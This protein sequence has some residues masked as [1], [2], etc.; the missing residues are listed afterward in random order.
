MLFQFLN[1]SSL[2]KKQHRH[3]L[4]MDCVMYYLVGTLHIVQCI[5]GLCFYSPVFRTVH[6]IADELKFK[7]RQH[8]VQMPASGGVS[9][10]VFRASSLLVVYWHSVTTRW[11]ANTLD[12]QQT[13]CSFSGLTP[14]IALSSGLLSY[15]MS[16]TLFRLHRGTKII[17]TVF[18]FE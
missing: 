17:V 6:S 7:Q 3:T 5:G 2:K 11:G 9:K 1:I 12:V 8:I 14:H 18:S 15:T 16:C 13:C 10:F 4:H